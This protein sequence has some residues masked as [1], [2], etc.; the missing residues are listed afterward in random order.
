MTIYRFSVLLGGLLALMACDTDL[1]QDTSACRD[2]DPNTVCPVGGSRDGPA[3]NEMDNNAVQVEAPLTSEE[4]LALASLAAIGSKGPQTK[5]VD[6]EEITTAPLQIIDLPFGPVLLT[7]REIKDGCH[8]CTGEIGVYYLEQNG[9]QIVVKARYPEA[10]TG[11]GWG[12]APEYSITDKF[13]PYP[14]LYAEGGGGGQGIFCS[15]STLVELTPSGPIES[16]LINTG[17][18]NAGAV[19]DEESARE[20]EGKISS[21]RKSKSFDVVAKGSEG[22]VEHYVF[23]GGKF[24]RTVAES[25]M[26]C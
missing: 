6:G 15:G 9:R 21:I 12:A 25:R 13:T 22:F 1:Y 23:R 16:D 18:S 2:D 24:V 8:A 10:L 3:Q 11:W 7:K 4:R 17:F 14:A 19:V 26:Q 5:I 20:I